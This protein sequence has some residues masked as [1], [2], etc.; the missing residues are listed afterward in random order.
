MLVT[1]GVHVRL[2]VWM[3]T[4]GERK[5]RGHW[6]GPAVLLPRAH[7]R[8]RTRTRA[9]TQQPVAS[10]LLSTHSTPL[11]VSAEG[12]AQLLKVALG[13]TMKLLR[14]VSC[15]ALQDRLLPRLGR[16]GCQGG[17]VWIAIRAG[18]AT[19]CPRHRCRRRCV[20]VRVRQAAH[21][22][23]CS[24]LLYKLAQ[25][26]HPGKVKKKLSFK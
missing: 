19:L 2:M 1:T 13:V 26:I 9:C 23:L 12:A 14:K 16:R 8:I 20:S 7:T 15:D 3:A 17:G 21:E 22:A 4:V 24:M 25:F 18:C 11:A 10:A 6:S 5:G